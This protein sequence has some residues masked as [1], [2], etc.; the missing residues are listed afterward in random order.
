MTSADALFAQADINKDGSLSQDEFR[1]LMARNSFIGTGAANYSF[2]SNANSFGETSNYGST[3]YQTITNGGMMESDL[4]YGDASASSSSPYNSLNTNIA[5]GDSSSDSV[6]YNVGTSAGLST[7]ETFARNNVTSTTA[8]VQHYETDAQGLFKDDNPQIIRKPAAEGQVTYTQ[9]IKVRF[10]Q[11][12]AVPP[13]GVSN[14][15]TY[16]TVR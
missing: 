8:N 15:S 9:N 13:P 5:S 12:P 16:C 3:S 10:L 7:G 14:L 11:P 6:A 4:A 1:N 2:G